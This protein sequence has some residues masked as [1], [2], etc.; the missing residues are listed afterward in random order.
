MS[1][2]LFDRAQPVWPADSLREKNITIGLYAAVSSATTLRVTTAEAYRVFVD[3]AFFAYGPARCA[4]GHYRVDELALPPTATHVAIE[5]VHYAVNSFCYLQADGFVQAEILSHGQVIAATGGKGFSYFRLSGRVQNIQ[6][7]SYQRPFVDGW[8]LAPSY[9]DWRVGKPCEFA[10][11]IEVAEVEEKQLV[12][13]GIPHYT[14]TDTYA[15]RQVAAGTLT[16]GH[17]PTAYKKDR[18]LVRLY[19]PD[20]GNLAGYTEQELEWHLSDTVQEWQNDTY[21]ATDTDT[22]TVRLS[23]HQWA[24]FS[25]PME[26]VGFITAHLE[27]AEDTSLWLLF[28]EVLTDGDVDPLR[29]DCCNIVRLDLAAGDYDFLTVEPY[30]FRYL[31]AVCLTGAVTI[32][33]VG[34]KELTCPIPVTATYT[35][36]TPALR[37]IYDAAVETFRQNSVDIFMDCPTR[38]RA[39]WLCDSF[40]TAR[41]ER[42]LTGQNAIERNFLENYLLPDRFPCLPE[43]MVPMCY[44]ADHSDGNFIPNWAMWLVLELEDRLR[45]VGDREFIDRFRHRVYT[46]LEWFEQYE[47]ADGLLEHLP[48]WVF[49]EWSK[50]NDLVQDINFPS[51]MLYA[52]ML[53][54]VDA[55]YGDTALREK[56]QALKEC[57][58]QRSYNGTFF[59]D[60]EV[61]GAD[62]LP[63]PTGECTETCQYY[64]FFTGVATPQSHPDLWQTLITDFGPHRTDAH[65]H[66][67]PANAFI[68]NYLR[69]MLLDAEGRRRQMLAEIE[70]YF[71]YMAART[72]TLWEHVGP[73][74]SCNHGFASYVTC[75]LLPDDREERYV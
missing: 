65:P 3:G 63:H 46:L 26:K 70:G 72:G 24:L 40:F 18:S 49:V 31:K 73:T 42:H 43:G 30:G 8:Q 55:L 25:L 28:D 1:K 39:G 5:V 15:R 64:A 14:F 57:I 52:R 4:H 19:D 22:D 68:G 75:L 27:C 20:S 54:A 2:H 7:Y 58:R 53:E 11:P 60:N 37:A 47:N 34:I 33:D 71:G 35:A 6:R 29:M 62:G 32:T 59:T 67:H 56:A 48:G 36:H 38:E 50:A 17:I 12:P 23:A 66:V 51:N 69:L 9:A 61:Y 74:A 21:I 45:R 44:P 10:H 41:T 16:E 13:R